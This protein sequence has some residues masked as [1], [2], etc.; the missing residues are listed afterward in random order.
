MPARQRQ[1][2][3][4]GSPRARGPAVPPGGLDDLVG[5]PGERPVD[6]RLVEDLG[7]STPNVTAGMGPLTA[8][9]N[10]EKI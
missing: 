8:R 10:H 6:P 1:P 7:P 2:R 3:A 9:G 4:Y 5:D